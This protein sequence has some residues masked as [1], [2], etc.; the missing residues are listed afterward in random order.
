MTH[1]KGT[2]S[3]RGSLAE[4]LETDGLGGF[5]MGS[6]DWIRTRRYHALLLAAT[7]PPEGRMVLVADVEVF[8]ETAAGRFPL[9]SHR[10]RG[11]HYYPDGTQ[12]LTRFDYKPWPRWE[13][14]L[15]DE[16]RIACELIVAVGAPRTALRW[17]K[18]AGSPR[19]LHVQP[20]LAPRDY[21]STHHENTAFRFE[22]EVRGD[23]VTWHPYNGVPAIGVL[24]NAVYQHA[25]DWYRD[26]ELRDE[27]E[28]GLSCLEDAASPG[29]FTFDLAAGPAAMVLGAGALDGNATE[30]VDR[31]F[32]SEATRRATFTSPLARAA[33]AYLVA[34][35]TGKTI[36]AGYPWFADWGR[37]TFI[38]LRGLCLTTGRRDDARQILLQWAGVVSEGM[39]PN[40]FDEHSST[41]EYNSV[42]AALWFVIAADAYLAGD[43][44]RADRARIEAAIAAIIAGYR[45][46]TRH[47]IRADT[48]GLLACGVP[49]LQL[50]WMDAKVG[51]HVITPRIGKP[52]EIQALWI[53]ALAIAGHKDE[54]ARVAQT[55]VARF[56]DP[57]R[58]QLHDV[59]DCDHVAGKVDPTCRPNQLFAIGGL[60]LAVVEGTRARAVVD[61][62]ERELWTPAGP[63]SLSPRDH[64]Y[65]GRYTGAPHERD[66]CYHNGP[67]WPWLAGA[68]VEAWVRV[69]GATAEVKRDARRRFVEPLLGRLELAGLGHLSEICD[70]DAPHRP[71]GCP[72]QAWSVA[73][74][75]RLDALLGP[76]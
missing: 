44:E 73:E 10:Y 3:P 66:G 20:L 23:L 12:H 34:R 16:T 76:A 21:H 18:L 51:D 46:G 31:M 26:F 19:A 7:T 59:I 60:P 11:E 14:T 43:V 72:F 49:G 71:V 22:P 2:G 38:S 39:L 17:T 57:E 64:R 65:K 27:S 74:L 58:Q 4:W 13:W 35:G 61:V 9:S 40:R 42:D 33:D 56:W 45:T 75:L 5:A 37:D 29:V 63:R 8:V 30:V 67:V 32:T 50:T 53:N 69:R 6:A 28:R 54:A 1:P 24:A 36:V 62:C 52:V 41:P 15:P 55:F 68:F 48:D 25:P 47:G 70:G